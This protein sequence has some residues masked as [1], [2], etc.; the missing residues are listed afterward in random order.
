MRFLVHALLITAAT[1]VAVCQDAVEQLVPSTR[2]TNVRLDK[3]LAMDQCATV[4][5]A[6]YELQVKSVAPKDDEY[7]SQMDAVFKRYGKTR[8]DGDVGLQIVQ[9]NF[10]LIKTALLCTTG[11]AKVPLLCDMV[12]TGLAKV[13]G[14]VKNE[15]D[16]NARRV[17]RQGFDRV[18]KEADAATLETIKLSGDPNQMMAD[19]DSYSGI[20]QGLYANIPDASQ[21]DRDMVLAAMTRTLESE[22]KA[23]FIGISEAEKIS[24]HELQQVNKNVASLT[25]TL[26]KYAESNNASLSRIVDIQKDINT[27]LSEMNDRIGKTERGVAFM[28][29]YFFSRMTPEEKINALRLDMVPGIP[30]EAQRMELVAE[31]QLYQAQ[32]DLNNN[33]NDFLGGASDVIII[34]RGLGL[35]EKLA[36]KMSTAVAVGSGVFNAAMSFSSG[37][38]LGTLSAVSGLFGMGG[39]DIGTQRH[40]QIMEAFD[41]ID[42]KL[43]VLDKKLQFLLNG[44]QVIIENQR[45]TFNALV[46]ISQRIDDNQDYLRQA[47]EDVHRDILY[48]RSI[49]TNYV[50]RSYLSC[51]RMINDDCGFLTSTPLIDTEVNLFPSHDSLVILCEKWNQDDDVAK[52]FDIMGDVMKDDGSF[53][54]PIFNLESNSSFEDHKGITTFIDSIHHPSINYLISDTLTLNLN[55]RLTS[56]FVPVTTITGLDQKLSNIEHNKI[57]VSGRYNPNS[58]ITNLSSPLWYEAV[59]RHL[60][61]VTNIHYYRMVIDRKEARPRT[62]EKLTSDNV[63]LTGYDDLRRGLAL[64]DYAIAQQNMYAGDVLLPVLLGGWCVNDSVTVKRRDRIGSLINHNSLL[65][66]N[67][68]IYALVHELKGRALSTYSMAFDSRDTTLM[69]ICLKGN[70]AVNWSDSVRTVGTT[71]IPRGWSIILGEFAYELPNAETLEKGRLSYSQNLETLLKLKGRILDEIDTYEVYNGMSAEERKAFNLFNISSLPSASR[72]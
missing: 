61:T 15:L 63:N 1:Q 25:L 20:M 4:G 29:D 54:N 31:L 7:R 6:A 35:D 57:D 51:C 47:L 40:K 3:G 43:D 17:L 55:Q 13:E 72:E 23:G 50:S 28:Q 53:D 46:S 24:Q 69:N 12:E 2:K 16:A 32:I 5:T 19:L 68:V 30:D 52:C 14:M 37:N 60:S 34:A 58:F 26:V 33:V 49:M 71:R 66:G 38:Y 56:L 67:F 21:E 48:D 41:R 11:P 59:T 27:R 39:P 8:N 42:A 70:W 44:Q 10:Y 62:L 64:V 45:N 22:M 18:L 65:A 36:S 9:G